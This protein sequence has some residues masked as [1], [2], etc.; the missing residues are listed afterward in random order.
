MH[1]AAFSFEVDLRGITRHLSKREEAVDAIQAACE[2]IPML[3]GLALGGDTR[4]NAAMN[5]VHVG[6]ARGAL[7]EDFQESRPALVADHVRLRGSARYGP[8]LTEAIVLDALRSCLSDI[9]ALYPGLEAV[10]TTDQ[11]S[12]RP[13]MP[14]FEVSRDAAIVRALNR[15]YRQVRGQ[16]QPTGAISPASF[17]GTDAS[18]LAGKAGIEGV[19]CGPGGLYNTMPDERVEIRDYLDAVR[20]YMLAILDVCESSGTR[21]RDAVPADSRPSERGASGAD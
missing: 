19:V 13:M 8:G 10:L 17:F 20:I 15:A 6:V 18:H 4:D 14:P 21:R 11:M 2:L 9:R 5:R 1:A 7:G 16:E 12:G 3:N